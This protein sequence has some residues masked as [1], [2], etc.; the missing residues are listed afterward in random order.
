MIGTN[1][2]SQSAFGNRRKGFSLIELMVAITI[3]IIL[4]A[5]A[6][7]SFTGMIRKIRVN[8]ISTALDSTFQQARS[9]AIKTNALVLV[10]AKDTAGTGC[11]GSSN[12]GSNGW[13]ICYDRAANG[14]CDA[15]TAT[16]PNPIQVQDAVDSA[17]ASVSGPAAAVRFNATGSQGAAGAATVTIT[18]TGAWSGATALPVSIAATGFIKSSKL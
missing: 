15:S 11:S 12:W 13:I 14:V 5:V 17:V 4:A 7:P 2:N 10:C 6:A 1:H 18:V 9:E 8:S 3:M 16:Y